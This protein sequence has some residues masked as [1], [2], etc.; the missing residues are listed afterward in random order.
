MNLITY[1][2]LMLEM[3]QSEEKFPIDFD[4]AW[5]WAGYS[6]KDNAKTKLEKSF[7]QDADYEVLLP[8]QERKNEG[9]HNREIIKLSVKCFKQFCMLSET[10]KGKE[11]REYYI[12]L[13]TEF[14]KPKELTRKELALM[15]VASENKKELL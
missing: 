12:D 4:I 6:R 13:E 7:S 11:V 8:I 9:G 3:I 5:D 2:D 14:Y 10:V 1:K 15:V